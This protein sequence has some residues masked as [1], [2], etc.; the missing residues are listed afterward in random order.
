M[1]CHFFDMH[2][3]RQKQ[4]LHCCFHHHQKH[5]QQPTKQQ[6]K[7]TVHGREGR[8]SQLISQ[9]LAIP[10]PRTSQPQVGCP[11]Y[12]LQSE[13][14]ESPLSTHV[15]RFHPTNELAP[16]KPLQNPKNNPVPI[17]PKVATTTPSSDHHISSSTDQMIANS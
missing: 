11:N 8:C 10:T 9:N 2:Q 16:K 17:A 7:E 12:K 13:R 4:Q 1:L 3:H 14:R 15:N 5:Q 6:Q